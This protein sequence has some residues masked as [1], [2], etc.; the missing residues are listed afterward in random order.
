MPIWSVCAEPGCPEHFP[1]ADC[2]CREHMR[3]CEDDDCGCW[4]HVC[5]GPAHFCPAHRAGRLDPS[6]Y[7]EWLATL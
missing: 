1:R 5:D 7:I 6:E 4:A 3:A 2:P